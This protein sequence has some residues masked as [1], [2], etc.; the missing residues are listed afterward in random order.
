MSARKVRS[1]SGI[2]VK[3]RSHDL[4]ELRA[5]QT[6]N[7]LQLPSGKVDALNTVLRAETSY[8]HL[9]GLR[10]YAERLDGDHARALVAPPRIVVDQHL[11][12]NSKYHAELRFAIL[13]ELAHLILHFD[14]LEA[15]QARPPAASPC[16]TEN[17]E[18]QANVMAIAIA[19]PIE[20]VVASRSADE[21]ATLSGLPIE[22]V[23][24]R[25][26]RTIQ[27]QQNPLPILDYIDARE[28][29][30]LDRE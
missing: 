22:R 21:L 8:P 30:D 19:A 25:Y 23:R 7:F 10:L 26:E 18:W 6:R 4:I 9:K 27:A 1:Y 16:H 2:G 20:M 12:F 15:L 13:H 11:I 5:L 17:S 14:E 28:R 24:F 3:R 29:D